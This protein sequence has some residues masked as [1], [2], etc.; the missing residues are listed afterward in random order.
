[1]IKIFISVA[2]LKNLIKYRKSAKN[3][4]SHSRI[5]PPLDETLPVNLRKKKT[6]VTI[7]AVTYFSNSDLTV[8]VIMLCT[9]VNILLFCSNFC[10]VIKS[11]QVSI[12]YEQ[13]REYCDITFKTLHCR[14]FEQYRYIQLL[15]PTHEVTSNFN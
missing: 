2:N 14:V 8:R 6:K 9:R 11:L 13:L 1:M 10:G 4:S 7:L 3:Q 12:T 15:L 5:E